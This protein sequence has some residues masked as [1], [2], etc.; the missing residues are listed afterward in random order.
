MTEREFGGRCDANPEPKVRENLLP[1]EGLQL[2][3]EKLAS[4]TEFIGDASVLSMERFSECHHHI[5]MAT[6]DQKKGADGR[7]EFIDASLADDPF[8]LQLPSGVRSYRGAMVDTTSEVV[9]QPFSKLD[10]RGDDANDGDITFSIPSMENTDIS[11]AINDARTVRQF[12]LCP[13]GNDYSMGGHRLQLCTD[14]CV[15]TR[16]VPP[17]TGEGIVRT[18]END[19]ESAEMAEMTIR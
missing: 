7:Q 2:L 3:I 13:H 17:R 12:R 18:A 8:M 6:L 5:S 16:G 10:A 4:G 15:E 19:M 11:L 1:I 14:L 9:T